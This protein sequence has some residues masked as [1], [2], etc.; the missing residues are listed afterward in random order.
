[1]PVNIP[2]GIFYFSNAGNNSRQGNQYLHEGD[3][4][5]EKCFFNL[6]EQ[7]LFKGQAKPRH[8]EIQNAMGKTVYASEVGKEGLCLNNSVLPIGKYAIFEDKKLVE[9]VVLYTGVPAKRPVAVVE[10]FLEGLTKEELLK[11]LKSN[12]PGGFNYIV[13]FCNRKTFWRYLLVEKYN[14]SVS[15]YSIQ[16][17]QTKVSFSKPEKIQIS[18]GM[19]ALK[20]ESDIPVELKRKPDFSFALK[21][22]KDGMGNGRVLI[23]KLPMASVEMLKPERVNDKQLKIFSEIIV[24]I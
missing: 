2:G 11:T 14:Q 24:F 23:D 22:A 9:E 18:N 21:T 1:V 6:K 15:E 17:V 12:N 4:A 3:T 5:S 13:N 10:L 16:P 8:I 7:I 19:E 20:F